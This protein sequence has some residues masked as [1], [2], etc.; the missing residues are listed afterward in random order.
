ML[1]LGNALSLI[2]CAMMTAIGLVKKKERV[3]L[4][5]CVQFSFMGLGNLAL[6]ALSGTISN[7]LG[8]AR[9]LAFA[10]TGGSRW[11]KVLFIA[12]QVGM[13]AL[14]WNGMAIEVLPILATVIFVW[15]LDT[16]SDATF[17]AVN[18]C[19]MVL[20]L[21]YDLCYRNYVAFT[22]DILTIAS[23]GAAMVSLRRANAEKTGI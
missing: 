7:L 1:L 6:G 15:F 16:K 22:F 18:I 12:I 9:N 19:A 13:T 10:K 11:M 20:W 8:I 5:Q 4:Y 14:S 21:I 3:L 23:N 17:K 2:G